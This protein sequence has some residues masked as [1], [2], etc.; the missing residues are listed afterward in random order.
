MFADNFIGLAYVGTNGIAFLVAGEFVRRNPRSH[1]PIRQWRYDNRFRLLLWLWYNRWTCSLGRL[2]H[3]LRRRF[4][5]WLL[6]PFGSG[7]C[8]L[9]FL[10][11]SLEFQFKILAA[12]K[13]IEFLVPEF[14]SASA[15][16]QIRFP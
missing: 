6:S 3:M 9:Q 5:D 7:R 12:E 1:I 15:V 11:P 10:S 16:I 8:L 13:G 4:L 14:M 2:R